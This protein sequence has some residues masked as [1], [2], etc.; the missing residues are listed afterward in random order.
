MERGLPERENQ[1]HS[2][3]QSLARK[4]QVRQIGRRRGGLFFFPS[5]AKSA[6]PSSCKALLNMQTPTR[7]GNKY[8]GI[9]IGLSY[10]YFAAFPGV[11]SKEGSR[12]ALQIEGHFASWISRVILYFFVFN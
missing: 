12:A 5:L 2:Y 1:A 3:L 9:W 7:A 10:Y 4:W 6:P 11:R 8:V